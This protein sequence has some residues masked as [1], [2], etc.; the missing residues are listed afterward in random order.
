MY[1][2][3]ENGHYVIDI[4]N[5]PPPSALK[6]LMRKGHIVHLGAKALDCPFSFEGFKTI[7]VKILS[8]DYEEEYVDKG[9]KDKSTCLNFKVLI[10]DDPNKSMTGTLVANNV[11]CDGELWLNLLWGNSQ[12]TLNRLQAITDIVKDR[13]FSAAERL[14]YKSYKGIMTH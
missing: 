11:F 6:A 1:G 12:K 14:T 7:N 5:M 2:M 4:P 8:L 10:M 9:T 13:S 3:D